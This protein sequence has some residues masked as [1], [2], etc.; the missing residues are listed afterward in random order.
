MQSVT[1]IPPQPTVTL[2]TI[3]LST[4]SLAL[5]SP[6]IHALRIHKPHHLHQI[7]RRWHRRT[8]ESG[9]PITSIATVHGAVPSLRWVAHVLIVVVL[10]VLLVVILIVLIVVVLESAIVHAA[11]AARCVPPTLRRRITLAASAAAVVARGSA[12]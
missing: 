11:T 1:L 9:H 4:L 3:S 10:V 2:L 12:C 5:P 6:E 7:R 8:I